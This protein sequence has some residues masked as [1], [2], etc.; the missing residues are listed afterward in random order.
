MES[1]THMDSTTS[2]ESSNDGFDDIMGPF[3]YRAHKFELNMH[4][5][6]RYDFFS[7]ALT[8]DNIDSYD[9][10]KHSLSDVRDFLMN[11]H[12]SGKLCDSICFIN[13]LKHFTGLNDPRFNAV[14]KFAISSAQNIVMSTIV[15]CSEL[16]SDILANKKEN[17]NI[18]C[19]LMEAI[20]YQ[21]EHLTNRNFLLA[22]H[23]IITIHSN[24]LHG[25]FYD[26]LKCIFDSQYLNGDDRNA[27]MLCVLSLIEKDK[28]TPKRAVK[29][30]FGRVQGT[31]CTWIDGSLVLQYTRLF[32]TNDYI[33]TTWYRHYYSNFRFITKALLKHQ[34]FIESLKRN[35]ELLHR[36]K[37]VEN[38]FGTN[39]LRSIRIYP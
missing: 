2:Y 30:A 19:F 28:R 1:F 11:V 3:D 29:H 35:P 10:S 34:S 9:S 23:V 22:K 25:M 24:F 4:C 36:M 17:T 37:R 31:F 39:L 32:I 13:F 27:I 16:L 38:S 33:F 20:F 21:N 5:T 7:T 18:L 12:L 26:V 14:I 6:E 15:P 8:I